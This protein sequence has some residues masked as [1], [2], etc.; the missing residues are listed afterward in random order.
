[1]YPTIDPIIELQRRK[2]RRTE[3]S[4]KG[5]IEAHGTP[6]AF[7]ELF[8][9]ATGTSTPASWK[10]ARLPDRARL[11]TGASEWTLW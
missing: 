2:L 5:P 6:V 8:L 4:L 1:M 11:P 3:A 10:G 9:R 7:K